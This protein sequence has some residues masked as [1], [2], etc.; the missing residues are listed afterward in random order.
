MN[1]SFHM[2]DEKSLTILQLAR[3]TCGPLPIQRLARARVEL[4]SCPQDSAN[5]RYLLL[6][7]SKVEN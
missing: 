2:E 6:S 4:A 3:I 5:Q 7:A 1:F